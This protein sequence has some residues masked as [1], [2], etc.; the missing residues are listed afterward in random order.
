NRGVFAHRVSG[1]WSAA[2][3][4]GVG[5]LNAV[6]VTSHEGVETAWAV[7]D[8][9][10]IIKATAGQS[11]DVTVLAAPVP[12]DLFG[13]AATGDAVWACGR[14]GT[15]LEIDPETDLITSSMCTRPSA[16]AIRHF[17][18]RAS[19]TTADLKSMALGG[20]GA[21]WISGS[22]GT[23][24]RKDGE[25]LPQLV[26]SGVGGSLNA[27]APTASGVLAVGDN[28]VVL[29]AT[30]AGVTLENEEPGRFLYAVATSP[31]ARDAVAIAVGAGG[32]I[33]RQS[34]SDWLPEVPAQA[35]ATFEA[36]WIDASGEA[37]VGGIYRVHHLESRLLPFGGAP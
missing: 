8:A 15:L 22:F 29:R 28:G 4:S 12:L 19:G 17:T 31:S 30:A 18:V 33:L 32:R 14:S 37:L 1:A 10:A 26:A 23:L 11:P 5:D 34:G 20:D 16:H 7:G 35:Q 27:L 3:L 6:A 9:G 2:P 13:V 24:L 25:G 36:A 21:I